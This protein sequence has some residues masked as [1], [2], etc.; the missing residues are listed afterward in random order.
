MLAILKFVQFSLGLDEQEFYQQN[1]MGWWITVVLGFLFIA[2]LVYGVFKRIAIDPRIQLR[3][4]SDEE[5]QNIIDDPEY[6]LWHSDAQKQLKERHSPGSFKKYR[7]IEYAMVLII[8]L[9]AFLDFAIRV[10]NENLKTKNGGVAHIVGF[11]FYMAI[12]LLAFMVSADRIRLIK[13]CGFR[14]ILVILRYSLFF[15][16]ILGA[17]IW[18]IYIFGF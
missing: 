13:F 11:Y 1:P 5:I 18:L 2:V 10:M 4:K 15:V 9:L 17:L 6:V 12:G 3:N 14:I 8:L 16:W 7:Y